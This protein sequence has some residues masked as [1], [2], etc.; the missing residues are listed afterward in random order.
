M[1]SSSLSPMRMLARTWLDAELRMPAAA[2]V[3]HYTHEVL[4]M[5]RLPR[6]AQHRVCLQKG[7][8]PCPDEMECV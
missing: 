2:T 3:V 5:E 1:Y 4:P 7:L 6:A 8:P